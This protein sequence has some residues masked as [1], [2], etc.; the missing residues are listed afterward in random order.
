M[1]EKK[2][3]EAIHSSVIHPGLREIMDYAVL[4]AGKLFRPRLVEAIALDL[5]NKLSDDHVH[6]ASAIELHHAYTLVHDD[7]PAMDND[8]VRRGK[9]ST[10]AQ[11]GEWKAI[12]AGDALL[13]ASFEE[14]MKVKSAKIREL[15]RL[16]SWCT[17]GKGLI[18][19]QYLDLGS[20]GKVSTEEVVRIHELK[21]ARLI[22]V[23]VAGAALISQ[24]KFS[25]PY[26]RLG[27]DIGVTFQ[28]LDDL[29]ELTV[30]D[31]SPHEKEINP[32]LLNRTLAMDSF[33]RSYS[34]L[35]DHMKKEKL[36][37]LNGMLEN[38]FEDNRKALVSG[39]PMIEA[40][41]GQKISEDLKSFL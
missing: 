4:P 13:I 33:C 6:L 34:N 1:F 18:L 22:Q 12:L 41:L 40:H 37:H 20:L 32:F 38:Y 15:H 23:A 19:G 28:L 26:F 11:F 29:N 27:R 8:L 17:G 30:K 2:L 36:D 7:L 9:P 24:N 39:L 3:S 14:L 21:T 25:R 10:H 5:N 16:F 31:L 35:R